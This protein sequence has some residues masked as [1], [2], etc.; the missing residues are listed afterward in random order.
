MLTA[1][2]AVERLAYHSVPA[3]TQLSASSTPGAQ[4]FGHSWNLPA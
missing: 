1:A 4:S 2:S 3:E